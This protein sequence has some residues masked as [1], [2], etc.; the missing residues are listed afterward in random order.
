MFLDSENKWALAY[1]NLGP[2]V[3]CLPSLTAII[4]PEL[5][6]YATKRELQDLVLDRGYAAM[7]STR[8]TADS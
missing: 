6:L 2:A 4:S 1:I 8:V 5:F 7:D 3:T